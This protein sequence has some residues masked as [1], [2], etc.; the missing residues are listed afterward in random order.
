MEGFKSAEDIHFRSKQYTHCAPMIDSGKPK[1]GGFS[2]GG[3]EGYFQAISRAEQ[4][5][6]NPKRI[7]IYQEQVGVPVYRRFDYPDTILNRLLTSR[8]GFGTQ[9]TKEI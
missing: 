2:A 7:R 9:M 3:F 5:R 6:V 4:T 1:L 8:F